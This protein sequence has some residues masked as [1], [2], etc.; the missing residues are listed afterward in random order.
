[1]ALSLMNIRGGMKVIIWG[2]LGVFLLSMAIGGLVGGANLIDEIF[3]SNLSGNAA[4]AVNSERITIEEL[5]QAIARQTEAAREQFGELSDRL[6]DQAENRAWENLVSARLVAAQIVSRE[7]GAS[8]E[9]IYHVLETYPPGVLQQEEAFMKDGLFDPQA[10]Y[11]ALRNPQGNEWAPVEDY[12]RQLLP[13]EKLTQRVMAASFATAEEVK[14]GWL[15]ENLHITVDYLYVSNSIVGRTE[16]AITDRDINRRYR[17]DRDQYKVPERRIIEYVFWP[18][19]A[20]AEDS[21]YVLAT[22]EDL[23]SRARGGEDFAELA[24]EYSADP[25]SGTNGGDLGWFGRRQMVTPF[26]EA[27]FNA[28][29]GDLVGPVLSQFG[30]HIIQVRDR[31]TQ[32]DKEEVLASHI[33]LDIKL[34]PQS[35]NTIRNRANIFSFDAIDSSFARA[36]VMHNMV[37]HSSS[38]LTI[39]EKFL[40]PPVGLLRRA[41]HFG[42]DAEVGDIS[43]VLQSEATIVVARL[44]QVQKQGYRPLDEVRDGISRALKQEA[45]KGQTDLIMANIVEQLKMGATLQ[46]IADSI[47][48]ADTR[49]GF[50]S[51]ISGSFPFIGRSNSLTGVLRALEL[52]ETSAPIQLERGQVIV[53]LIRRDEPDWVKFESVRV[54][55]YVTLSARR[56]TEAWGVWVADLRRQAEVIDNRHAFF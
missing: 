46:A 47:P 7:M 23:L 36:A 55:N 22:A 40:P 28:E 5:S 39:E 14:Q 3:G 53:H 50:N 2:F 56:M 52:G 4:G 13:G 25:G 1:M 6:L 8:D 30:Y 48:E 38:P 16:L 20:T 51:I 12:L 45:A 18:R 44:A 27:A 35:I 54:S 11:A 19:V 34:R 33:L 9:E 10:Y 31:R 21:A 32:N 15:N 26:S 37:V 41:V 43:A 49:M 29:K 17:K 24:Q 42:F